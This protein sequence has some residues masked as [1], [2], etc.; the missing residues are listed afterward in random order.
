MVLYLTPSGV[1]VGED[2]SENE[3]FGVAGSAV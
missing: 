2:F 3:G 1:E